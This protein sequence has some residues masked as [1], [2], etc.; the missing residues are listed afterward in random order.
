MKYAGHVTR[1]RDEK[2]IF[3]I[4]VGNLKGGEA[5]LEGY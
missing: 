5:W 3:K 2:Y 1:G 4:L